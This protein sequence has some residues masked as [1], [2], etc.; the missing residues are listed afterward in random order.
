MHHS[1]FA[2][3]LIL[4]LAG[5]APAQDATPAPAGIASQWDVAQNLRELAA[6]SGQLPALLD[7]F[8]PDEWIAK[9]ASAAYKQ[10]WESAR[11]QA[12]SMAPVVEKLVKD[13]EKLSVVLEVYFRLQSLDE[14]LGSLREAVTKYQNPALAELLQGFVNE[15]SEARLQLRQYLTDLAALKEEEYRVMDQEAQRCRAS[16]VRQP[17]R[18]EK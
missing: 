18:G 1:V 9:G 8:K 10:Q 16:I 7:S 17:G 6:H 14:V 3:I 13:V 4:A 15:N 12:Q 5:T 11:V 2:G